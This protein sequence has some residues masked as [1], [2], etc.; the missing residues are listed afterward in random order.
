M[1]ELENRLARHRGWLATAALIGSIGVLVVISRQSNPDALLYV[2]ALSGG[3]AVVS[4]LLWNVSAP[5]ARKVM[6]VSLMAHAL[7]LLGQPVFENDHYRFIWD[8]WRTLQ[9]GTPYGIA[10]DRYFSDNTVPGA[11]RHVL[12]GI[13]HPELAT[14]YGPL[15]EIWFALSVL[16]GG[17]NDL[18][19]RLG[20]SLANLGLIG[21]LL[22]QNRPMT[23]AIYAWNPLVIAETAIHIHPDALLGL[24]LFGGLLAGR[25]F[26][27]VAGILFGLAAATKL[28]AL[29]AWPAL[30]RLG[31]PAIIAAVVAVSA[32]YLPFWLMGGGVG[33]ETTG[34]FAAAWTFNQLGIAPLSLL[35]GDAPGRVA[36]ALLATALIALL[37]L[38]SGKFSATPIAAIFGVVLLFAP[39][40]NPWYLL[41]LLP[42]AVGQKQIWPFAASAALPLSY[43]TGLN[44][45]V[46]SID[47]FAIHPVAWTMEWA[48]LALAVCFDLVRSVREGK[49]AMAARPCL[50]IA[51]PK[52]AVIIPAL[53]EEASVGNAVTGIRRTLPDSIGCVIVVD[54]GSSDKTAEVA[55]AAGAMVVLQPERG[56]GAACLAGLTLM[57]A[58]TNVVLFMDADGSDLPT[59]ARAILEPV[60]SGSAEMVIGSRAMGRSDPGAMTLPQRFG[61]RLAPALIRLIWGTRYTDLGPFRAI[62]RDNLERLAMQD[63]DFGWTVEMQVRAAK[64]GMKVCEVPVTYRRRI[65]VS[66]ISGTLKGVIGAGYKIIYVILREAFGETGIDPSPSNE[67]AKNDGPSNRRVPVS[68]AGVSTSVRAG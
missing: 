11:L 40:V 17:T 7:A 55:R 3:A 12:S 67:T 5:S 35:L 62:R 28:V 36:G 45:G 58:E 15:L 42:F 37:H 59:D 9:D 56:Y 4:A 16:V 8:G 26:P 54:N 33:L 44:L 68:A 47:P 46:E 34:T 20:F 29:A 39:A 52:V 18:A 66:K 1:V 61:N 38:R 49:R 50:P 65:G 51:N 19:L 24:T 60:F 23:V 27:L 43:L 64:L 48:I 53:N 57:P 31:K 32:L 30:L 41:W 22:R 6:A 25:R 21:L 10:P 2:L 63:R 13:N 14:I